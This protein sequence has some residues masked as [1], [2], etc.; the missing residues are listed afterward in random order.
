MVLE[1]SLGFTDGVASGS[2]LEMDDYQSYIQV[3]GLKLMSY[4]LS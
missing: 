2:N 1:L 4:A 3:S